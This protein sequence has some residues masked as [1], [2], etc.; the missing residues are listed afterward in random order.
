[1]PP[2]W[3]L[4][5]MR[6]RFAVA[7]GVRAATATTGAALRGPCCSWGPCPRLWAKPAA[8][9]LL[10]HLPRESKQPPS[11]TASPSPHRPAPFVAGRRISSAFHIINLQ[12]LQAFVPGNVQIRPPYVCPPLLGWAPR[13]HTRLRRAHYVP[14]QQIEGP[15]AAGRVH[16]K[17]RLPQRPRAPTRG[18]GLGGL[19]HARLGAF[20]F[21]VWPPAGVRVRCAGV[22]NARLA[23]C[24][25]CARRRECMP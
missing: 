11:D 13:A 2:R 3:A 21:K 7:G 12:G 16:R 4:R 5:Q 14:R 8:T 17:W 10:G 25:Q 9:P 18:A 24:A 6:R 19:R 22:L 1:M 20:A 23:Q 15:G